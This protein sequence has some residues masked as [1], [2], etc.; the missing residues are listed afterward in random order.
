M[1]LILTI[2]HIY[3][4]MYVC[5]LVGSSISNYMWPD[6]QQPDIIADLIFWEIPLL[7][8]QTTV[9]SWCLAALM[10]DSHYK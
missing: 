9:A 2:G 1:R 6:L 7:N 5:I 4:A 8:I 10:P 3:V